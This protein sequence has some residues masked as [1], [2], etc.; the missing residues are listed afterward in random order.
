M[1]EL[2]NFVIATFLDIVV[3]LLGGIDAAMTAL[4]IFIVLD[5]IT[6]LTAACIAG[7]ASSKQGFKGILKKILILVLVAVSVRIDELTNSGGVLRTLVIY[8]FVS[9]EGLS[10]IENL[11][12]VGVP[13]PQVLKRAIKELRKES[14]QN[15][16]KKEGGSATSSA[17]TTKKA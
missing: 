6:G 13:I 5:Y 1:K 17:K 11:G 12:Q 14:N 9:N 2:I 15:A 3:Y 7:E 8:Y 4:L 16:K 10:I